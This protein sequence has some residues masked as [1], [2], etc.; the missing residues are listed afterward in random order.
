M[1]MA[2]IAI[3]NKV[4][5]ARTEDVTKVCETIRRH[6]AHAEIVLADSAVL[7]EN[8]D[9]VKGKRVLVVE[10]GPTLT[11][12]EM[13]YG[14]GVIAAR[15]YG[16]AQLVDPRPYLKGSLRET[17][18]EYPGIGTV[19]PAM[20][21][22]PEQI[23]DL[24]AMAAAFLKT[25]ASLAEKTEAV[26]RQAAGAMNESAQSMKAYCTALEEGIAGLNDVL[27]QLG[28]KQVV[29]QTQPR[30]R[31]FFGRDRNRKS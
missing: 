17:F 13:K 4:D 25:M 26:H 7:V 5:S 1:L 21:Y 11:H 22:S 20:G 18:A 10:D 31:W 24:D 2:D 14:A 23:R 8:A 28:E 19:L 6:N 16:A 3:V 9:G 12:G 27:G 29:V 30:R 15:R